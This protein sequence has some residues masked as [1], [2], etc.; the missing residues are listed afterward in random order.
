MSGEAILSAENW[1]TFGRSGLRRPNPAG[2]ELTA[3][4]RLPSWWGGVASP[5]SR[6]P[7]SAVGLRSFGLEPN[8]KFWARTLAHVLSFQTERSKRSKCCGIL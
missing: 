8:E 5:S 2:G 4:P 6:T 7:S 3:L 1:K